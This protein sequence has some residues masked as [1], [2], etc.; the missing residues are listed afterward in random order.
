MRTSIAVW[1]TVLASA[2]WTG[3]GAAQTLTILEEPELTFQ[4]DFTEL[5]AFRPLSTGAAVA[6][7]RAGGEVYLLSPDGRGDVMAGGRGQGPDEYMQ[8]ADALPIGD[9]DFTLLVDDGLQRL[10]VLSPEGQVLGLERWS[11]PTEA[12]P[13]GR[14]GMEGLYYD[15]AGAVRMDGTGQVIEEPSPLIRI[16]PGEAPDT[17]THVRVYDLA[18]RWAESPVSQFFSPGPGG[19]ALFRL[20]QSPFAAQDEWSLMSDGSI[21]VARARP[22]RVDVISASGEV[23]AGPEIAYDA[24]DV[25]AADREAFRA[26]LTRRQQA[27]GMSFSTSDGGSV[28]IFGGDDSRPEISFP[29]IKA[30]FPFGGLHVTPNEIL[31]QRHVAHDSEY[32]LVDVVRHRRFTSRP[33]PTPGRE[34]RCGCDGSAPVRGRLRRVRP[35]TRRAVPARLTTIRKA[36]EGQRHECARRV[37]RRGRP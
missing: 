9:S 23:R 29:D 3:Q 1:A 6:V 13:R 20:D 28:P 2:A 24:V 18:A 33:D 36:G 35:S 22:Y 19:V 15:L 8:P 25:E 11:V 12:V 17:L 4:R 32:S 21:V 5:R 37:G 10:L 14:D 27:G 7:E 31:V 34:N 30:P 26:N 16:R